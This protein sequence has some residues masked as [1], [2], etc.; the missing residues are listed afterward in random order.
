MYRQQID[1]KLSL[2]TIAKGEASATPSCA[3]GEHQRTKRTKL[4]KCAE[5]NDVAKQCTRETSKSTAT[6]PPNGCDY[7]LVLRNHPKN[8]CCMAV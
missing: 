3:G 1:G 6:Q 4:F 8:C 2:A 7:V 5:Q